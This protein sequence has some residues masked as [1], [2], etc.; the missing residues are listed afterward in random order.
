MFLII[1]D[2]IIAVEKQKKMRR[3][4]RAKVDRCHAWCQLI[5]TAVF[6]YFYLLPNAFDGALAVRT[7]SLNDIVLKDLFF[8]SLHQE[9]VTGGTEGLV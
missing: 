4:I 9:G 2:F 7:A 6:L 5:K 1:K 8:A 3:Q